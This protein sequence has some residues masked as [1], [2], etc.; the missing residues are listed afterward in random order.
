M[1]EYKV[2]LTWNSTSLVL[3]YNPTGIDKIGIVLQRHEVYHSVL[4]SY[5]LSLRFLNVTHPVNGDGGY[6]FIKNAYNTNGINAIVECEIK[7]RNPNTDDYDSFYTGI[8]DFTPNQWTDDRG[9]FWE[10]A[11]IDSSR[12]QKFISRDENEIDLLANKTIGGTSITALTPS[13]INLTPVDVI[14]KSNLTSTIPAKSGTLNNSNQYD[15]F[16]L[17]DPVFSLNQIGDDLLIDGT[18]TIYTNSNSFDVKFSSFITI[19]Y[20]LTIRLYDDYQYGQ[21]FRASCYYKI[22]DSLGVLLHSHT[23]FS[24]TRLRSSSS[25][26]NFTISG[27]GILETLNDTIPAGGYIKL[28]VELFL[29]T[30]G[31]NYLQCD[32]STSSFPFTLNLNEVIE[33]ITTTTSK[34]LFPFEAFMQGLNITNDTTGITLTSNLLGS[35]RWG[36]DENGDLAN[37]AI[38]NG[39]QIRNYPTP[40]LNVTLRDLFKT[41]DAIYSI[42]LWYDNI[43]NGFIIENKEYFYQDVL[44]F[45]LGEVSKFKRTA[46]KESY[47]SKISGGYDFDGSYEKLQGALE[48]AVKREYSTIATVKEAIEIKSPYRADSIGIEDIRGLQYEDS[49]SEDNDSDN[50][51]FIVV[52]DATN[53]LLPDTGTPIYLGME[54]FYSYYNTSI[55]PRQNAVRWGNILKNCHYKNISNFQ[56]QKTDKQF[57]LEVDGIDENSDIAMS[58]L[59]TSLFIPELHS[60]ESFLTRENLAILLAN[61]HGY[62]RYS[63]NGEKFEGY[64]EKA[65]LSYNNTTVKIDAKPRN[66]ST[67]LRIFEGGNNHLFENGNQKISE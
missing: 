2:T 14:L 24:E 52:T 57:A 37:Y 18:D 19:P 63:Y 38:L 48:F 66:K 40:K 5:T 51:V 50:S 55:T 56:A 12:L 47:F 16:Y 60:I 62:F 11:L 67:I 45:D 10:S 65:E 31:S 21:Y 44:L 41:F 59:G 9:L 30:G 39:F 15:D 6:N 20:Y 13:Q 43:N 54:Y 33:G 3:G 35:T 34:C 53:P 32:Y 22:F 27:S 25:D 23:L 58:E 49:A 28:W 61:P 64:I 29:Y 42:G 17:D 4:R 1:K 7:R 26:Q 8:L 46:L 36:Y